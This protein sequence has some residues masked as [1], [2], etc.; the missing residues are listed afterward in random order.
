LE[1]KP[2]KLQGTFEIT[3]KKFGDSRGYF[4]ETFSQKVFAENGVKADWV[5]ENQSF[6]EQKGIVRGLHFQVP[7][8][9]QAKLLRVVQGEILDVFVDL[10]KHSATFGQWDSIHLSAENCKSV[11]IPRGFAHGFCTLTENVIVQYKVDNY[12]S[13]EHDSGIR[14]NDSQI[15]VDWE[16]IEPILSEK[17]SSLPFF[18]DFVSPF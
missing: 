17:D 15:G 2:L 3:L 18:K 12:Y 13:R 16:V 11:Y 10:R 1:I 5:Q 14:W 4:M 7:P 6:S 9:A 8:M